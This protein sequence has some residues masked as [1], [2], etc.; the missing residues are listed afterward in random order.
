MGLLSGALPPALASLSTA[1]L[2]LVPCFSARGRAES[3][4]RRK[5]LAQSGQGMS[6]VGASHRARIY[7]L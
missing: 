3:S 1:S 5:S 2:R 6:C 7:S 4:P